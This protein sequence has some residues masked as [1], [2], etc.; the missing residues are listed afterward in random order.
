MLA[1]WGRWVYR[2]RWWVADRFGAF[3]G[4]RRLADKRGGHLESVIIPAN[5][6]S[7]RAL[8]L[9]KKELPPILPS[10]G[11]IFRSPI[12]QATDPAFR[13]EVER[14]VAPLRNDPRVASVR[15]AY[16]GAEVDSRLHFRGMGTARLSR[17]R[18]GIN[19]EPDKADDGH[20]SGVTRQSAFRYDW[21]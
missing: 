18:S 13:A 19:R 10:F 12:L 20:L 16:D 4:A 15:T 2:F 21:R 17:W 7:A 3:P 6:E 5:S 9:I 14:A 8:D 11:L 1:S